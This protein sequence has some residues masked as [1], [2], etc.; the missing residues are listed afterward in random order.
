MSTFFGI[1]ALVAPNE[2][3]VVGTDV[4]CRITFLKSLSATPATVNVTGSRLRNATAVTP[5]GVVV[6]ALA[7]GTSGDSDG[8]LSFDV[9][10]ST[11]TLTGA[12]SSILV[13]YNI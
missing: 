13:Q 5:G 10:C 11:I 3:L 12:D 7:I 8:G 4:L 6:A 1:S 2:T 9:Q